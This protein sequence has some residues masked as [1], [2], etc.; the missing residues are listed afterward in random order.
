MASRIEE[1]LLTDHHVREGLGHFQ[2][3]PGDIT[4]GESAYCR[5][6]AIMAALDAR[7]EMVVRLHWS[8][9]PLQQADG[10]PFDL[11]SW[12]SNLSEGHGE[13]AV[14]IQVRKCRVHLRLLAVRLSEA[15]AHTHSPDES[16]NE[17][18]ARTEPSRNCRKRV[19]SVRLCKK[20]LHICMGSRHL[21][22][23]FPQAIGSKP[24]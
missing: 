24:V 9:T 10:S 12:L 11:S 21:T 3:H 4:V 22:V 19:C 23:T 6:G 18:P 8:S 20:P 15:A 14:W 2:R 7:A 13:Q 17:R 1:T 5:R 16:V